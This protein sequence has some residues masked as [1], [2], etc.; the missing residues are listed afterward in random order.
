[1]R[2]IVKLKHLAFKVFVRHPFE[3]SMGV[4]CTDWK[5]DNYLNGKE[6][7]SSTWQKNPI[8]FETWK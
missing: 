4:N 3:T 1:M 2:N 5:R 7:F 8:L 6:V